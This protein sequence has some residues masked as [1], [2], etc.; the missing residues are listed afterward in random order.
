MHLIVKWQQPPSIIKNNC[1]HPAISLLCHNYQTIC[2][3]HQKADGNCLRGISD[4][5]RNL[6]DCLILSFSTPGMPTD[7]EQATGMERKVMD[8]IRKGEV[9]KT[10]HSNIFILSNETVDHKQPRFFLG[11]AAFYLPRLSSLTFQT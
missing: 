5:R 3:F 7:D 11:G 6:S 4:R 10:K 8:T 9:S 1:K 2:I